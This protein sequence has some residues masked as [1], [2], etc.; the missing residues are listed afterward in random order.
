MT[1]HDSSLSLMS[2]RERTVH[3]VIKGYLFDCTLRACFAKWIIS[4]LDRWI[5]HRE[6]DHTCFQCIN[7]AIKKTPNYL[8]LAD[9]FGLSRNVALNGIMMC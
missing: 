2:F 5:Q 9:F 7:F 6:Q 3:H 4:F 8:D 1:L